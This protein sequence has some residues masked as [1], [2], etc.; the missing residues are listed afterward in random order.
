MA[1]IPVEWVVTD[2]LVD[3]REAVDEMETRAEA[4]SKGLEAERIWLVEHPPLYTAG[5]SAQDG[6][7][8]DP[9]A[10]PVYRTGRGGQYTYHGPGTA[11]GLCHAQSQGPPARCAALR[12]RA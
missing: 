4:I 3:Y 12:V 7:L 1:D 8:L 6:D 2:G 9:R 11:G 10:F 5:T